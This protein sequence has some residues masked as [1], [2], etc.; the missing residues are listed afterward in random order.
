MTHQK[1]LKRYRQIECEEII[2]T[3][4]KMLLGE[5]QEEANKKT[6]QSIKQAKKSIQRLKK[7]FCE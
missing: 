6:V 2:D 1:Q 3:L 7:N 4:D 5:L